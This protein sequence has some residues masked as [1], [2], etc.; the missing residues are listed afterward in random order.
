MTCTERFLQYVSVHTTSDESSGTHPSSAIQLNLSRILADELAQMQLQDIHIDDCGNV[1]ATLPA[2]AKAPTI[3]LIAHMDTSPDA[4]GKD[5]KPAILQNYDGNDI[6]LASGLTM[7]TN[8]FEYLPELKGTDL[9][10]TDGTTLLGADDK[11]GV[12][13]IM[14]MVANLLSSDRPHG[15]I[16]VIFTTDEEIGEGVDGLDVAELQ[17]DYAYTVDGGPIGEIEY[18]NFNAAAAVVRIHGL[19]IHPGSAKGKMKNAAA[20]ATQFHA[21]LPSAQ[22]PECTEGYEGFIHLRALEADVTEATMAYLLREHDYEAFAQQKRLFTAAAD[23]LNTRYGAGTVDVQITDSYYN[24]REKVEP[25]FHLILRAEE[26][27]R[28]KGIAPVR[29]PIRGGTDGARLSWMGLPCPNLSTGGYGF[30]GVYE[31]IPVQ[32][33]EQM[34]LVLEELVC[35][36]VE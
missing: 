20:I 18:E 4:S 10:V 5:I 11:A 26:A 29:V 32:A 30:H 28:A 14:T 6:Q 36:F 12:A 9:I 8:Q 13:E 15:E 27:F 2:T 23:Y 24:M 21:L 16:R 7:S 1:I 34:P 35:S 33:L 17:C 31:C 22:T 3:A 19:G 25:E